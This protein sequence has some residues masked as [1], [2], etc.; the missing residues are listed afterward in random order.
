MSFLFAACKDNNKGLWAFQLQHVLHPFAF[1]I[2]TR[3][4][5][6]RPCHYA[7]QQGWIYSL[8]CLLACSLSLYDCCS[9]WPLTLFSLPHSQRSCDIF[10]RW[11]ACCLRPLTF[12]SPAKARIASPVTCANQKKAS[13]LPSEDKVGHRRRWRQNNWQNRMKGVAAYGTVAIVHQTLCS[14]DSMHLA[15]QQ[16]HP[17]YIIVQLSNDYSIRKKNC[18]LCSLVI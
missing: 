14:T 5:V 12:P 16:Y 17:L 6:C 10:Q 7:L 1:I 2:V 9:I 13:I 3:L 11:S 4:E 18:F 15:T 8:I